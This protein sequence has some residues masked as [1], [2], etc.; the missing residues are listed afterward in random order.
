[1]IQFVIRRL[2]TDPTT[3]RF[4][5]QTQSMGTL[6]LDDI[7]DRMM[8]RDPIGGRPAA[9]A[10]LNSFFAVCQDRV[11][12]G[13]NLTTPFFNTKVG[14]RGGF[15]GPDDGFQ[16][17]RNTVHFTA[18]AGTALNRALTTAHVEKLETLAR[19]GNATQ[20]VDVTTGTTSTTLTKGGMARLTGKRLKIGA[21]A[22]EGLFL[23]LP[24]NSAVAVTQLAVN[25]P[26]ELV[27]QVP[28]T[29]LTAGQVVQLE[30]RNRLNGTADLRT[31]RL[32]QG[33]AIA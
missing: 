22:G 33:L 6:T 4:V 15:D 25:K 14:V 27:F 28:I 5:A 31:A 17:G 11:L 1:M 30:I 12:E 7:I 16:A 3:P 23:I 18:T 10:V 9:L 19:A 2:L 29:G 32:A 21:G 20:V 13:Y 8:E 24:D 26:S